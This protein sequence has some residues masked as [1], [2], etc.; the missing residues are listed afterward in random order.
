[1]AEPSKHFRC[2]C[3]MCIPLHALA[4]PEE[5]SCCPRFGSASGNAARTSYS[6]AHSERRGSAEEKNFEV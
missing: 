5:H 2:G 3:R 1:M 6:L 4:A